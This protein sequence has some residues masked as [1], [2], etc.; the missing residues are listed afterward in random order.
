MLQHNVSLLILL[1]RRRLVGYCRGRI[2]FV[3]SIARVD[4]LSLTGRILYQL[5]LADALFVQWPKLQRDHPRTLYH[6]RLF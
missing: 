4:S 5:R 2:V 3:E 6:G 1:G